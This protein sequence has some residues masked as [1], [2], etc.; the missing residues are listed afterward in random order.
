MSIDDDGNDDSGVGSTPATVGAVEANRPA[1]GK[2]AVDQE[3]EGDLP[4][5]RALQAE[6]QKVSK[7]DRTSKFRPYAQPKAC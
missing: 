6:V 7:R 2:M 3:N 1:L 4:R 5:L